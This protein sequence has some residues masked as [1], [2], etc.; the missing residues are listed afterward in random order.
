MINLQKSA[1]LPKVIVVEDI[2]SYNENSTETDYLLMCSLLK[3]TIHICSQTHNST[4][5]LIIS[6]KF[7]P[8]KLNVLNLIFKPIRIWRSYESNDNNKVKNYILREISLNPICNT[9]KQLQFS[10]LKNEG[11]NILRLSSI[12]HLFEED[13]NFNNVVL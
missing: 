7:K 8:E 3:N 11:N 6:S 9:R 5:F 1:N 4:S 13:C 12:K 2:T 10:L